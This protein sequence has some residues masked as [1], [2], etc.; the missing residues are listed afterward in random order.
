MDAK[1]GRNYSRYTKDAGVLLGRHIQLGRKERGL[2]EIDLADR[3]GV[4]RATLQKIEKGD[5]K[6]EIGLAFE[7]ATLVG[8]KLFEID[9]TATH[10]ANIDRVNDK[11]ALLPKSVR[12]KKRGLDDAF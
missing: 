12:K 8:V 9:S 3:A 1:K 11:I 5:L 2:T 6:C 4:S 10:L 7:V